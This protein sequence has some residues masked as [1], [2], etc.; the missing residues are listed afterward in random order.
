MIQLKNKE[1]ISAISGG[2]RMDE[3]GQGCIRIPPIIVIG[4]SPF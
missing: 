1:T 2:V 3:N 4:T